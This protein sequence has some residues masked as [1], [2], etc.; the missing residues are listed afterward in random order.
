MIRARLAWTLLVFAC[1]A[2]GVYGCRIERDRL[3]GD[4]I[5][6]AGFADPESADFH[7]VYLALHGYP[8]G[9]CRECH[10]DDYAGGSVGSSCTSAGC[11]AEPVESCGTCHAASPTSGAHEGHDVPCRSCHEVPNDARSPHHPDGLVEIP[12]TGVAAIGDRHPEF[13]ASTS[14]CSDVYC[15]GGATPA[16]QSTA[17]LDC[18]SCHAAP[19][20]SHARFA[21]ADS[22]CTS[23][24]GDG[25]H[26]DGKV[27]LATL[28]CDACHGKGP[29]G[30][31]PGGLELAMNGPAVGAHARHLDASIAN[32][33]GRV[34]ACDACHSVPAEIGSPGHVDGTAPADVVLRS[35]ESYGPTTHGCVVGCHWSL[36]PGPSWD[37]D[38]GAARACDA[39]HGL[40]PLVTRTGTTHP[41]VSG[42]QAA[43]ASCHLFDPATH[44]DGKVDF[45]W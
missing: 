39:C 7:G 4:T 26:V 8:L 34:V 28:A 16:W 17:L 10:G 5:H 3:D 11:H 15:H 45:A 44:V 14:R 42:G 23:C 33:I 38:S 30:A 1:A 41:P 35:G 32:R 13:D 43:C 21:T 18:S 27:D 9:D 2:G 12:L 24:H 29:L 25:V 19:P 31:P 40:P 22:D 37:D 6:E 20:E 36:D